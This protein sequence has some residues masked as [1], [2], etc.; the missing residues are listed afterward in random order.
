MAPGGS[1]SCLP[2]GR[3]A[4]AANASV[5]VGADAVHVALADRLHIP[6]VTWD[7]EQRW[8]ASGQIRVTTP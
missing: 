8:R 2:R 7:Q 5:A 4:S 1:H 6:L 3:R